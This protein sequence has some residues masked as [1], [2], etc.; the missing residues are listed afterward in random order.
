MPVSPRSRRFEWAERGYFP[1]GRNQKGLQFSAAFIG[2]GFREVLGGHLA[3]GY[4]H[5]TH[6]LPAL[7]QL[8]EKRLGPPPR[9]GDLLKHHARLLDAEATLQLERAATCDHQIQRRYLHLR[10]VQARLTTHQA[11]F[12]VLKARIRRLPKRA[13]K[14]KRQIAAHQDKFRRDRRREKSDRQQI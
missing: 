14:L 1:G 6:G 10:T 4:A 9:R 13:R 5:L 7:L 3:P 11:Q 8:V 2:A 12:Q